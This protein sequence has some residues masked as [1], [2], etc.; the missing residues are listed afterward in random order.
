MMETFVLIHV[1][2]TKTVF[3]RPTNVSTSR[4]LPDVVV[5]GD[6]DATGQGRLVTLICF[7]L[8]DAKR[9]LRRPTLR[10]G[11]LEI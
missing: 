2:E 4:W 10:R 6:D 11:P 9:T 1:P 7:L 3:V 5:D 8:L